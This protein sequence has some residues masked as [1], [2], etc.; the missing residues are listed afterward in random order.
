MMISN[1]DSNF[2]FFLLANRLDSVFEW[3]CIIIRVDIPLRRQYSLDPD[4]SSNCVSIII[5][6][7]F[8]FSSF[9]FWLNNKTHRFKREL[10]ESC[11]H[12]SS[13]T[14]SCSYQERRH[15]LSSETYPNVI[16]HTAPKVDGSLKIGG[17][18]SCQSAWRNS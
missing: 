16:D 9:F 10:V 6:F 15:S 3:Q 1:I 11:H 4:R 17:A 18:I 8:L 2:C 13:R 5:I 7:F 12:R 14:C